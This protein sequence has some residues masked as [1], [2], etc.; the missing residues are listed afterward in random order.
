ML[1]TFLTIFSRCAQG[2]RKSSFKTHLESCNS[3]KVEFLAF[4]MAKEESLAEN[5]WA[6]EEIKVFY[7]EM[8]SLD[9]ES[10]IMAK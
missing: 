4:E 2:Q 5:L 10:K 3:S 1:N 9:N 6:E 7:S 8:E